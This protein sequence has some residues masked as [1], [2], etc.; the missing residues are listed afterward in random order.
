VILEKIRQIYPALTKSQK[1]LADFIA[2]S[3]QE[4][5]F[6]TASRMAKRL[7]LNEAT[8]IRF[9]QRLGY[10]GYPELIGEVQSIVREELRT[11]GEPEAETAEGELLL[12]SL[13]K[14]LENLSRAVSHVSPEVARDVVGLLREARCIYVAGGGASYHL[15]GILATG[16]A[17][18]GVNARLVA[19]EPQSLALA[20]ASLASDD[21]FVGVVACGESPEIAQA[22]AVARER[23]AR[24]LAVT[25]SP[26]SQCARAAELALVCPRSD[27]SVPA[28][29]T[30]AT[31]LDALVQAIASLD[32]EGTQQ[33]ALRI[34]EA[35]GRLRPS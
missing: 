6:M 11:P 19:G 22:V 1:R 26:V 4:A 21:T 2:G 30:I 28:L 35:V 24:T 29:A 9:A 23:G 12:A 3:Y 25:W 20:V 16:L 17:G 5:A 18:L 8:V 32:R 10:S 15:A 13:S 14:E 33:F 31:F 27:S 34:G 7:N